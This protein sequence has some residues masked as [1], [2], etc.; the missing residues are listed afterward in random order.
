M[1]RWL[2]RLFYALRG[3]RLVRLQLEDKPKYE[4]PTFEGLL[5]GR[6][7]GHYILEYPKI[8][9][10]NDDPILLG[11]LIEVPVERVVFIQLVSE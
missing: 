9:K 4:A 6:W 5:V 11:S 10:P 1:P 2:G 8:V 3:K 7:A